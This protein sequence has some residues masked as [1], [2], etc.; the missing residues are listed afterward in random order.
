MSSKK[1]SENYECKN[2]YMY[3][4]K[5][6][7][8]TCARCCKSIYCS[9]A[10][11]IQDWRS[12]HKI[13][14]KDIRLININKKKHTCIICRLVLCCQKCESDHTR[15]FH[16]EYYSKP[17][18]KC[19]ICLDNINNSELFI[20]ECLHQFH[21]KCIK[22]I[23]ST[24]DKCPVCRIDLSLDIDDIMLKIDKLYLKNK[25]D[26]KILINKNDFTN[27]NNNIMLKM[28]KSNLKNKENKILI[29]KLIKSLNDIANRNNCTAQYN[30]GN[31][32]MEGKYVDRNYTIAYDYFSKAVEQNHA[33][34]QNNLGYLYYNGLGVKQDYDKAFLYYCK[35]AEQNLTCAEYNLGIMY[36]NGFGVKQNYNIAIE[37]YT[38]ASNQNDLSARQKVDELTEL[39]KS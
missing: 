9:K 31:I 17:P 21:I 19:A 29:N 26:N 14:C 4:E 5:K 23:Q 3:L 7:I 34:A 1:L 32:Y 27:N 20:S 8:L 13:Y 24:S 37:Y 2:C 10:C 25:E 6:D 12:D 28:D 33:I 35:A 18:D 30:L 11:Q 15:K 39:I 38:K 16:P 36:E 22:E